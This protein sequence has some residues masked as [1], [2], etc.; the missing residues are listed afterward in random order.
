MS[1]SLLGREISRDRVGK[2]GRQFPDAGLSQIADSSARLVS[3]VDSRGL[4]L[5]SADSRR[6][7]EARRGDARRDARREREIGVRFCRGGTAASSR[8]GASSMLNRVLGGGGGPRVDSFARMTAGR[9]RREGDSEILELSWA[10]KRRVSRVAES[11]R[12]AVGDI[13]R[14]LLRESGGDR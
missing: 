10:G 13:R 4:S 3:M 9:F 6:R 11:S 7:E 5:W 8:G 12:H 14:G 1:R 2:L